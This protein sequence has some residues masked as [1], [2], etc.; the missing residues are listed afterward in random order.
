MQRDGSARSGQRVE[1]ANE[2]KVFEHS[3]KRLQVCENKTTKQNQHWAT[4]Y[5]A[6]GIGSFQF[7]PIST[8]ICG[9]QRGL[10][11]YISFQFEPIS[12]GNQRGIMD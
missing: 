10:M 7:E 1:G 8:G 5:F 9:N 4:I 6:N 11:D 2:S 3:H 12:S